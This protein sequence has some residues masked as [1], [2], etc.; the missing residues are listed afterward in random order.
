MTSQIV[1]RIE[2]I[3]AP[4]AAIRHVVAALAVGVWRLVV[5]IKHRRELP[6]LADFDDRLLADIG[7]M[8]SDLH[9]A[10]ET[11]VAGTRQYVGA[12]ANRRHTPCIDEG[13]NGSDPKTSA[14]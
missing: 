11:A 13:P 10:D 9:D 7:L 2:F 12:R 14:T 5:A 1:T 4:F 3:A 6:R 8:R